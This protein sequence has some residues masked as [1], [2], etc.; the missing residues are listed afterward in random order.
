VVAQ[1]CRAACTRRG[2]RPRRR[3]ARARSRPPSFTAP[4]STPFRRASS[5][6]QPN[7][8]PPRPSRPARPRSCRASTTHGTTSSRPTPGAARGGRRSSNGGAGG[9]RARAAG[10]SA[11]AG[12][13]RSPR[14]AVP[15]GREQTPT[16]AGPTVEKSKLKRFPRRPQT[17]PFARSGNVPY[18]PSLML[19]HG[20]KESLAMLREEGMANVVAR[21]HRRAGWGP[22]ARAF[23]MLRVRVSVRV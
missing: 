2:P 22:G 17:L 9:R 8:Q 20:L 5:N 21:H 18:T 12:A 7:R 6:R 10:R 14:R 19:L 23:G 13:R 16:A 15:S 3:R 4:F 1:L 11:R